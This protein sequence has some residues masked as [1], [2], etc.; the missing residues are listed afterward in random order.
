VFVVIV[1]AIVVCDDDAVDVIICVVGDC[2]GVGTLVDVV[3]VW[4]EPVFVLVTVESVVLPVKKRT[5][6]KR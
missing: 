4:V 3:S 6:K 5:Q 1:G 2:V